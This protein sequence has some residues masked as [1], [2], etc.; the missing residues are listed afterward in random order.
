MWPT[1]NHTKTRTESQGERGK[2]G[3]KEERGK[4]QDSIPA[5]LFPHNGQMFY[6]NTCYLVQMSYFSKVVVASCLPMWQVVHQANEV[7]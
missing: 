1:R 3:G 4:G 6:G 2:E 5:L 7:T